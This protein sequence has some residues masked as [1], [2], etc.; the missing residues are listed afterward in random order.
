MTRR[1][2]AVNGMY[3][4]FTCWMF[5]LFYC[6]PA[7]G[8]FIEVNAV[9]ASVAPVAAAISRLALYYRSLA[10][11][12]ARRSD[13][14]IVS[15]RTGWWCRLWS[16]GLLVVRFCCR[17]L[18]LCGLLF[19]LQILVG[20]YGHTS[21]GIVAQHIV[22]DFGHLLLQSVDEVGSVVLLVLDVAL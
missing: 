12:W 14:G 9:C 15:R 13:D 2:R 3:G 4:L 21:V 16:V 6:V 7:V 5:C 17:C 22:H 18:L 11:D 8:L 10:A 19:L 20:Q 1:L